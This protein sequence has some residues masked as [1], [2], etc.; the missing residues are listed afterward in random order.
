MGPASRLACIQRADW[1]EGTSAVGGP[2]YFTAVASISTSISG[3]AGRS[4]P[5]SVKAG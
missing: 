2:L 4:I 5:K 3:M 1:G